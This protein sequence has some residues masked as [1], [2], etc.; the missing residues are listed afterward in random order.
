MA[1]QDII[2]IGLLKI[3]IIHENKEVLRNNQSAGK[4]YTLLLPSVKRN[5]R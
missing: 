5:Y 2:C 1:G 3:R 4:G